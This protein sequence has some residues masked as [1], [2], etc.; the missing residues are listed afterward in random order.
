MTDNNDR[1][2]PDA[3]F[4]PH[5]DPFAAPSTAAEPLFPTAPSDARR[6]AWEGT[7]W[8]VAP[9]TEPQTPHVPS[10]PEHL[11]GLYPSVESGTDWTRPYDPTPVTPRSTPSGQPSPVYIRAEEDRRA[12]AV[13]SALHHGGTTSAAA[14]RQAAFER[15]FAVLMDFMQH[16][17]WPQAL[18][19]LQALRADY[20]EVKYLDALIAEAEL[21][22]QLMETWSHKI[23]G[24]R[25]TVR[26]EWLLRRSLP[27]VMVLGLFLA[28]ALFYQSYLAPSRQVVAM[29]RALQAQVQEASNLTQAGDFN[30]AI[31]LYQDVLAQDPTNQAA[32]AGL[33]E[34]R[35][36]AGLAAS[37][38]IAMHVMRQGNL[39][40]AAN[41]LNGIRATSP[42]YRDVD[43]QLAR[44][45]TLREAE[46]AFL[47]AEE[48]FAQRRWLAAIQG[49]ERAAQI[50]A[51]FRTAEVQAHLD[52][53]Y[54]Y[55]AQQLLTQRPADGFGP[56]QARTYLRRAQNLEAHK[57]AADAYL[58]TLEV[59]F[60][61]EQAVRNNNLRD[62]I[63]LWRSIYDTQPDYIGGH[64]A[65]QLYRAYLTLAG[66][67]TVSG[68]KEYARQL[69]ALAAQLRVSDSSEA[70]TQLALL[71]APT[72]TP[73]PP[74]TPTP[75]P[76]PVVYAPPPPPPTATPTPAMQ[77]SG[78]IAFRSTREGT[79]LVYIMRPDGSNQQRAPEE[80]RAQLNQLY[81]QQRRAPEQDRV[82][83][84]QPAPG[85]S[86]ANIYVQD[87][88]GQ[89]VAML[90]DDNRDE[91]D[92]VW[93][94][95]GQWVA[96][97]ANHPGNDEIFLMRP[98][99]NDKRRLT[100]N[101]WEWDKHPTWSPDS[102]QIAFF[103]NRTGQRQI[104]VMSYDGTNQR[105][106][107]NNGYDDWDPVWLR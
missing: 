51:E 26:Q 56:D 14:E 82:L 101:E 85:R 5:H 50:S 57:G 53:A 21:K 64:L 67:A 19:K 66:Q 49:Y 79:E 22:A 9:A 88:N 24:R 81:D 33:A 23:K 77:Y 68:D 17:A 104:W 15:R 93:A 44:L 8:V 6:P 62:A 87:N 60:K 90:T 99:G 54:F 45:A 100:W 76:Q 27:F 80:I 30:R 103:S 96:Y 18:A 10:A 4:A 75:V 71:S 59:Y 25:L 89:T 42:A 35:K 12:R 46:T 48:A 36:Q 84:V 72:P 86:D 43:Q 65:D 78:W 31:G 7:S 102:G 1:L 13:E 34:A 91:Y 106:I 105:N 69:Y 32:A 16:G 95:N 11:P 2:Y 52:E 38:D 39:T 47:Q 74:P 97:V 63:N 29:A 20:P 94:P 61:G 70:R 3:S 55:A 83:V 73:T 37:Y 40:R 28:A 107:S 92:P 41:L 98:D 58:N